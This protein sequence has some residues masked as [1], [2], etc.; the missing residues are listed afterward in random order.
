[1]AL[2]RLAPLSFDRSL[3]SLFPEGTRS[4]VLSAWGTPEL[5]PTAARQNVSFFDFFGSDGR[6]AFEK[7]GTFGGIQLPAPGPTLGNPFCAIFGCP[8]VPD[9]RPTTSEAKG[10]DDLKAPLSAG[11]LSVGSGE[12]VFGA[13][14]LG[15]AI[16]FVVRR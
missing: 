11:A 7:D 12:L 16:F 4:P 13:L 8:E 2:D 1:M 9:Q 10:A 3:T 14:I 15:A 6:P 5:N